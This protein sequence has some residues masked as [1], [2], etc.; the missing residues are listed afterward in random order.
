MQ[1]G[2]ITSHGILLSSH[3]LAPVLKSFLLNERVTRCLRAIYFKTPSATHGDFFSHEDRALLHDL[4]KASVDVY[5]V[6]FK[7]RLLLKHV[8]RTS[9]DSGMFVPIER[10]DD[11][12]T[13]V[14]FGIYGS[15]LQDTDFKGILIDL[16]KGLQEMKKDLD[17]ELF[18][19]EVT[20]AIS[21]GGG[22]GAMATGN[23]IANELE[24]LSCGHA[25]DFT[26]P[27][28]SVL[29]KE[30]MNPYIQAKMTYRLE[31]LVVRQSEFRLDFP[32]LLTGGVGTDF[33][34]ALEK[35]RTQVGN[36]PPGPILLFGEP[37]YW[38][39]KISSNY[40]T[41]LR[42]GTIKGSEWVSNTFFV[43]Q[44]AKQALSV[45]FKFFTNQLPIGKDH[46]PAKDGFFDFTS[47][48]S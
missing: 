24:I 41:N 15:S 22:P 8:L 4:A 42:V 17:H 12:K 23:Q 3:F 29:N 13:S 6:D 45:Y 18:N 25:V 43:V 10:V 35:L 19:P 44:T 37:E 48:P 26:Q 36:K 9:W 33:E 16:F 31:Q 27:Y 46:P 7:S 1:E 2:H 11:F 40:H 5:W 14:F 38:R 21:T 32:I 39:S 20:L 28:D 30:E 47:N 34:L